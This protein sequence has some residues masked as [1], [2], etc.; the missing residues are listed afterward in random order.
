M[1]SIGDN[2][3]E[4]SLQNTFSKYVPM[5][6]YIV[7]MSSRVY[8]YPLPTLISVLIAS[9]GNP[10]LWIT[11]N[12]VFGIYFV[13]LATYLY[14]DITDIDLDKFSAKNRPIAAG[15]IPKRSATALF[16]ILTSISLALSAL[17]NLQTALVALACVSLAVVYSHPKTHLKD[18]FP[19]KT[20]TT[21][22]G[23]GLASIIGGF[24]VGNLSS[25]VIFASLLTFIYFFI[26]GPLGDIDDLKADRICRRH[27]LPVVL[28][29]RS[30]LAMML[31]IP[32]G[33]MLTTI[34]IRGI[35]NIS[36]LGLF[37]IGVACALSFAFLYPLI[38]RWDDR[39]YV[40]GTRHK[41]R[42]MNILIQI[43]LLVGLFHII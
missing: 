13:A 5:L 6:L 30:T 42:F 35:I 1:H 20:L 19:L 41:V 32:I 18:K 21:A 28:G 34:F 22:A 40:Q 4:S 38:K 25:N 16:I 14:N 31:L 39:P 26:L 36:L 33:I 9:N 12:V 27:T 2:P 17:V 8:F 15:K 3:P 24:A 10:A 11:G 23:G 29:V 7:K 43:G 37:L